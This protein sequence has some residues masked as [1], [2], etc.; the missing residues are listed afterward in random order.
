MQHANHTSQPGADIPGAAKVVAVIDLTYRELATVLAPMP[1]AARRA[2]FE[3]MIGA[4]AAGSLDI[5]ADLYAV[6][7]EHVNTVGDPCEL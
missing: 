1:S 5:L 6:A 7:R 2:F 3:V 4:L